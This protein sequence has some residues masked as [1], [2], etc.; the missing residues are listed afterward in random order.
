[1]KIAGRIFWSFSLLT[2]LASIMV[3]AAITMGSMRFI[4]A[5]TKERIDHTADLL[6]HELSSLYTQ[7]AQDTEF[8]GQ[9]LTGFLAAEPNHIDRQAYIALLLRGFLDSRPT[10]FKAVL[11]TPDER[12]RELVRVNRLGGHVVETPTRLLQAAGLP[13]SAQA[14]L[15]KPGQTIFSQI[16]LNREAGQIEQPPRPTLMAAQA[17]LAADGEPLAIVALS[18]EMRQVFVRLNELAGDGVQLFLACADSGKFLMHPDPEQAFGAACGDEHGRHLI[19]DDFPSA[20][21]LLAQQVEEVVPKNAVLGA[22]GAGAG[23]LRHLAIHDAQSSGLILGVLI[24]AQALRAGTVHIHR[25]SAALVLSFAAIGFILS[26]L[27][28]RRISGPLR[29]ITR[30]IRAAFRGEDIEGLPIE[31]DDEIGTLARRFASLMRKLQAKIKALDEQDQRLK[32]LIQSCNDAI[33]EIDQDGTIEEFNRAA[34][35]LFGYARAEVVGQD[36]RLLL[37][38]GDAERH[39]E[40]VWRYVETGETRIIGRGRRVCGRHKDGRELPLHIAVH[41][42]QFGGR[43]KFTG[44]LR[45]AELDGPACGAAG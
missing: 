40:Y 34:E 19:Q 41:P 13:A 1:M 36:L 9:T 26:F 23:L 21:A 17:I 37:P 2:I 22:L 45:P 39:H 6:A 35:S 3:G 16:D 33:I 11:L 18:V 30:G 10:Y 32:G 12:G 28:E 4:A 5:A 27:L 38:S 25:Q 15:A 20:T 43:Y 31:R 8:L 24:S 42:F 44:T 29:Q 7:L 14:A